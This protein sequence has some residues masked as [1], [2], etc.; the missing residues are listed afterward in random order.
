MIF[1]LGKNE[2]QI[3][4]FPPKDVACQKWIEIEAIEI[5]LNHSS[6]QEIFVNNSP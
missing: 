2:K 5:D 1:V 4:I 3:S 6:F